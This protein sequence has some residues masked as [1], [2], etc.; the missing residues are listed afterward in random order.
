MQLWTEVKCYMCSRVC[1][2]APGKGEHLDTF[3]REGSLLPGPFCTL[4]PG[5][6]RCSR[7]GSLVY[8]SEPYSGVSPGPVEDPVPRVRESRSPTSLVA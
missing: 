7:C 8:A 5:E 6:L 3:R 1:G 2:E 4:G